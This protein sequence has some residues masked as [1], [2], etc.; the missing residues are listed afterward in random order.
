MV[1]APNT[2]RWGSEETVPVTDR[3]ALKAR[4]VD[5]R[6]CLPNHD[7]AD[8][9][10]FHVPGPGSLCLLIVIAQTEADEREGREDSDERMEDDC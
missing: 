6:C 3:R 1:Y 10:G 4:D 9:T 2:M 5:W 7:V 8:A